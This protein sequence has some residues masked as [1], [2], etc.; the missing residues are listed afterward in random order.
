M[1]HEPGDFAVLNPEV[2]VPLGKKAGY[3]LLQ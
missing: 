1:N 3:F 2:E